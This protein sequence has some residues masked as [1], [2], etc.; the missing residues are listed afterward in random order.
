MRLVIVMVF[1][2]LAVLL[3]AMG[4]ALLVLIWRCSKKDDDL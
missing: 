2:M 3:T 4:L 1:A